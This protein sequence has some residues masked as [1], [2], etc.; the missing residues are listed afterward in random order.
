MGKWKELWDWV[1]SIL[2][3]VALALLIRLFLFEVF[4]VEGRSMHPTLHETERLMVNKVIYR[5]DQPKYG[6]IVVF[7]YE[8][9]RD[10]I[11]R[12]IGTPGDKI[13]IK[14]GR[15][16][17]NGQLLE[18][19]YL[20]DNMEMNDFGPVEVPPGFL[21]LMGDY[22][23]NSMDSRDPRVGFVSLEDLK[24]RAFFIFWPPWEARVISSKV[25]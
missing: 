7:E 10:F 12:V 5:F 21:F 6:D 14:T 25:E 15:V 20:L 4:V 18:E 17:I 8:P 23:I 16:Y 22:R 3:A 13:E 24:G 2:I 19:P 1:R 9:G 11:K